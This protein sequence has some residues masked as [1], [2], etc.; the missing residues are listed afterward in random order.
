LKA[1]ITA[2]YS[3]FDFNFNNEIEEFNIDKLTPELVA[4]LNTA[5][6]FIT[7]N[8]SEINNEIFKIEFKRVT[9]NVFG[10]LVQM[11]EVYNTLFETIVKNKENFQLDTNAFNLDDITNYVGLKEVMEKSIKV[12]RDDTNLMFGELINIYKSKGTKTLNEL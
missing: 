6:N 1:N 11:T 4:S 7:T 5:T 8:F 10:Y 9:S 12:F 2:A 3:K